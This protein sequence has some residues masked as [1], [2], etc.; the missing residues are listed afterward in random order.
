MEDLGMEDLKQL[1]IFYKQKAADLEYH[2][3]VAQ[4]KLNNFIKEQAS[5]P[6]NI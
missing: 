5:K 6:E 1:V 4:L 2:M 3:L